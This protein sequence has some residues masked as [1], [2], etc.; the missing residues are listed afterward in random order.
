[1]IAVAVLVS[2]NG[3]LSVFQCPTC[4]HQLCRRSCVPNFLGRRGV[5]R[6]VLRNCAS[7]SRVSKIKAFKPSTLNWT[8]RT[9]R[10]GLPFD[11]HYIEPECRSRASIAL[12]RAPTPQVS[13]TSSIPSSRKHAFK[14]RK[15]SHA[16]QSSTRHDTGSSP[17]KADQS[18]TPNAHKASTLSCSSCHRV[19]SASMR[20]GA[21]AGATCAMWV[22]SN[23][24]SLK[25]DKFSGVDQLYVLFVLAHAPRCYDNP[26]SRQHR[27]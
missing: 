6:D 18:P 15:L 2:R 4:R 14:K 9:P 12:M 25:S 19:L 20:S 17:S 21:G 22:A 16:I 13:L 10:S 5:F 8:T 27:H 26:R 3:P 7:L 1:M 23:C 24:S 11:R